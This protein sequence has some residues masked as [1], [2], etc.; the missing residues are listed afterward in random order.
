[1]TRPGGTTP[2]GL[3][4][5]GS[6]GIH[7]NTPSALQALAEAIT[8][9]LGTI[10]A[11]LIF[12]TFAGKIH[13]GAAL[14]YQSPVF[15]V[16]FPKLSQVIGCVASY[17]NFAGGPVVPAWLQTS[18]SGVAAGSA[19]PANQREFF[20]IPA[21]NSTPPYT[22]EVRNSDFSICALAWGYPV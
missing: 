15:R 4:Y 16:A 6:A 21:C 1:M 18:Y 22:P 20:L 13:L 8:A 10:G 17:G 11:G 3:P 12:D 14:G 5:P 2:R 7:A 9:Q 19:L